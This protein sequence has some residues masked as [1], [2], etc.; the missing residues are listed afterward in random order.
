MYQNKSK[1]AQ[2]VGN[3]EQLR[4]YVVRHLELATTTQ[5]PTESFDRHTDAQTPQETH[6]DMEPATRDSNE[7]LHKVVLNHQDLR[8]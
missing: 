8:T 7:K 3:L 1:G 5:L 2:Q 4:N 6:W